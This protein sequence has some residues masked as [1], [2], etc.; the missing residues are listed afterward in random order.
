MS[1]GRRW[2]L[3]PAALFLMTPG[4]LLVAGLDSGAA[5]LKID[6]GA[7]PAALGG[8]Y[9]AMSDDVNAIHYNPGGLALLPR[10]EVGATH[11][12]WLLGSKYD[13][14]GYAHPTG[15]GT[16]GLGMARL[17]AARSEARDSGRRAAGG[18]EAADMVLALGFG[19]TLGPGL[20]PLPGGGSTS[21]GASVKRLESRIGSYSASAVALDLGATHRLAAKPVS[22]GLSVLNLGPGMKFLDQTDPLPL[23]VALGGAYRVADPLSL[24]LDLRHEVHDGRTGVGLGTECSVLPALALRVGYGS[25]LASAAGLA[26]SPLAGLSGGVGIKSSRF[27]ADYTFAPWGGLGNVQR[28]SLGAGF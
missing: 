9:T 3:V 6:T 7:R 14:I 24:A 8:A 28:I 5:F 26:G 1:L 12:Q 22:L 18:V 16:F 11:A 19:A 21:V 20:M 10:R 2:L 25:H 17:E 4:S 15:L 27:A 13:F 23:T